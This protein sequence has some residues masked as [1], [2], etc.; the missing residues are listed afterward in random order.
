MSTGTSFRPRIGIAALL[1]FLF[2]SIAYSQTQDQR[3][4]ETFSP[5]LILTEHPTKSGRKVIFPEPVEIMGVTSIS[6][7][8]FRIH[9]ALG[10]ELADDF[11][12]N[13]TSSWRDHLNSI[14][15]SNI[16][17]SINLSEN[18]FAFLPAALRYVGRPPGLAN[19]TYFVLAYFDYPGN[20]ETG[21]NSWYD[22]YYG[23]T[24]PPH[25]QAGTNFGNTAYVHIFDRDDGKVVIQ[26]YYFYPFNDWQNNHEGDWPRVNVIVNSRNPDDAEIEEIDYTF[27]GKGLTYDSIGGRTFNPR[28]HFAPAE[29]G[30]HPVVY[31]GAGSHGGYPTGGN[32]PS[33]GRLT[34]DEDM[35]VDGIVLSTNVEDTNR[36]VAHGVTPL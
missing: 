22:Y 7:L 5:I 33:A 34:I 12:P 27:H 16:N 17:N 26:Y 14:Y 20:K 18:K 2:S 10:Q 35:T 21:N 25:S 19:G 23:R 3:L 11:Y 32:Y 36:E 4:A 9:N 15:Q 31:V 30:T 8:K 29:G 13:L 28:T 24:D 6:N 1:I